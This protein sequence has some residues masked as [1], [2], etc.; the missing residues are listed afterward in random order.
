M[1]TILKIFCIT[2]F[3]SFLFSCQKTS[4]F[5]DELAGI[6]LKS[7]SGC[8]EVFIVNPSGADDTQALKN[9]FEDAKAS[10]P[11]AIVQLTEGTYNIGPIDVRDFNGCFIGAG[12]AKTYISN[13][14]ELPCEEL[15][16]SDNLPYLM[17]F[18]GGNILISDLA[19]C[20]NDGKPCADSPTNAW[21]GDLLCTVLILG[22]F[23]AGYDMPEVRLIKGIVKN[24][25][26][27]AGKINGGNNIYGLEGNVNMSL[28]CGPSYWNM[29]GTEP[30]SNGEI[31]VT[32]CGFYQNNIGPD[33]AGFCKNSNIKVEN[34]IIEG[35]A[36]DMFMFAN[37][38]AKF[39]I[40]NNTFRGG[41]QYGL[42]IEDNDWG[43][44]P[45]VVLQ[46]RTEWNITGNRFQGSPGYICLFL[47]DSRR[48]THPEEGFPQLF[49]IKG[50]EF[51]TSDGGMAIQGFN[52]FETKIWNNKFLGSG[53]V[54]VMINGD[55]TTGTFAENNQII[56]NNYFG[57]KYT[58]A[59]V[60][61][62]PYTKNCKVVGVSSDKVVD[63]GVNNSVIGTKANK[64]GNKSLHFTNRE[65][66]NFK[67]K[68]K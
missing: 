27:I 24:V 28:Y 1:K 63:L 9:A 17:Q 13:L 12:K 21:I 19:F 20:I 56:G 25:D 65:L 50:N 33:F 66:T 48:T 44:Y 30:L 31:T 7:A 51:K 45:N 23:H 61:L 18:I 57:A 16:Q 41:Q 52:I 54:G 2:A 36:Y 49:N 68:M 53:A 8:G 35:C 10:G 26:F 4:E 11:G 59:S 15:Y 64:K 37:L 14:P 62:G 22:D 5:D 6:D 43:Y 58:D 39:S 29:T 42:W 38:G 32:G 47:D 46:N 55:E 40:K 60:Y 34:N 67:Q 3:L